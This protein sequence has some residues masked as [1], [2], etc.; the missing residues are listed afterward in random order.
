MAESSIVLSEGLKI[1]L[2]VLCLIILIALGYKLYQAVTQNTELAQAREHLE[3]IEGIINNLD[4]G[5]SYEYLLTGPKGWYFV[6]Y[7]R[8]VLE[9]YSDLAM[10]LT[11][12]KQSCLCI[13]PK[14]SANPAIILTNNKITENLAKYIFYLS[15]DKTYS[16]Y[17]NLNE[18]YVTI[19]YS[20]FLSS[21][22]Y[23]LET[24][25]KKGSMCF[26]T[27]IFR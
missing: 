9:K 5:E 4:H 14:P 8:G 16:F 24:C 23:G 10:P 17:S 20:S 22:Y 18:S 12:T 2:A 11:C 19:A 15:S 21:S 25:Q 6:G 3:T 1:L 13:C 27:K 7:N 26:L